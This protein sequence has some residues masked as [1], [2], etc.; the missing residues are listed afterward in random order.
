MS[1]AQPNLDR[2]IG[3]V[4]RSLIQFWKLFA[5]LLHTYSVVELWVKA[6]ETR[7]FRLTAAQYGVGTKVRTQI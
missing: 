7:V 3:F 2:G 1:E 5:P 6:E 4:S